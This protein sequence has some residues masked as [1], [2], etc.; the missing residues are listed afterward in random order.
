[1]K[2]IIFLIGIAL[3]L[4]GCSVISPERQY[5]L[6][7]EEAKVEFLENSNE[8]KRIESVIDGTYDES[9]YDSSGELGTVE[10]VECES[11]LTIHFDLDYKKIIGYS[12]PSELIETMSESELDSLFLEEAKNVILEFSGEFQEIKTKL[13]NE[14]LAS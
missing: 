13:E 10:P 1:M 7:L 14:F 12:T 4:S 8:L 2:K 3:L 5:E 6:K 11:G 9:Q